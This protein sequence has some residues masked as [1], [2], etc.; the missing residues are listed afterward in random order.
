MM[1]SSYFCLFFSVSKVNDNGIVNEKKTLC[2]VIKPFVFTW[3]DYRRINIKITT[4][5]D[6]RTSRGFVVG[7]TIYQT[8]KDKPAEFE[9]HKLKTCAGTENMSA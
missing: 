5:N 2:G 8:G 9:K 7:Y 4:N 3:R 6:S 1:L